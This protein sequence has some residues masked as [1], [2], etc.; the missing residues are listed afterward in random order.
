MENY[1]L[2]QIRKILAC[3]K[4]LADEEDIKMEKI[5]SKVLP[6]LKGNQLLIDW[7]LQCLGNE[8]LVID[9][10]K[11]DYETITFRKVTETIDDDNELYEHIPQSEILPDP[12]ENP[13]HIRYMNGRIFYGNRLSFPTKLSFSV[14]SSCNNLSNGSTNIPTKSVD[15]TEITSKYRCVH[16][17]KDFGDM[18]IRDKSRNPTEI[19]QMTGNSTTEEGEDSDDDQLCGNNTEKTYDKTTQSERNASTD[20]LCDDLMLKAH[21]IRLNPSAHSSLFYSNTD[22]LNMLK[23]PDRSTDAEKETRLSP[24]KQSL[25]KSLASSHAKLLRKHSPNAKKSTNL[26]NRSPNKKNLSP[27][28][29]TTSC[30]DHANNIT[31]DS[32]AIQT[33]KKLKRILES[34]MSTD[35][36]SI[37]DKEIKSVSMNGGSKRSN[38][39]P[40]NKIRKIS[41]SATTAQTKTK[42]LKRASD[43][44]KND[45]NDGKYDVC[46]ATHKSLI[47]SSNPNRR[48]TKAS[49]EIERPMI[50][51]KP[52]VT[53]SRDEDRLLLEQIKNGMDSNYEVIT[54]IAQEFPN[55]TQENVRERINF[56]IDFL[57]KLR[58]KT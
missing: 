10:K 37:N 41:K 56:L 20:I 19:D 47:M 35:N 26:Y 14:N 33:A 25:S 2:F 5:R 29:A 46:A 51:E 39:I 34:T 21:A 7:F 53:W 9:N 43:R 12:N 18:K 44:E 55:K 57:T 54:Q 45:T 42:P 16:D 17:I 28:S 50:V 49:S 13:C 1:H 3:L 22:L 52:I 23:P 15:Y 40:A 31:S 32:P 30:H 36:I 24:K 38:Q 6:L 48:I 11:D 8:S 58:N 27:S 4:E